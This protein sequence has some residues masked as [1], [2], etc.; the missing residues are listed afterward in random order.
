VAARCLVLADPP[1]LARTAQNDPFV[2]PLASAYN[3][4]EFADGW[5]GTIVDVNYWQ[6]FDINSSPTASAYNGYEF[7]DGWPGTV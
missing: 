6:T 5:P 7:A 1:F 3:G 2:P 4:Y